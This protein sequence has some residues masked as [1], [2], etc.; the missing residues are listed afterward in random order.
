MTKSTKKSGGPKNKKVCE[1]SVRPKTDPKIN[2]AQ[3]M[4]CTLWTE[5]VEFWEVGSA[6]FTVFSPS[7]IHGLC[8]LFL[9]LIHGLCAFFRLLLTPLSTAHW[10]ASAE[11]QGEE[12]RGNSTLR[13][14]HGARVLLRDLPYRSSKWHYRQRKIIFELIM[15][16]IA[17]TD[18]DENY[19]GINFS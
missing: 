19:F 1:R 5:T 14:V 13:G 4:K 2:G 17:D 11:A 10:R 7:Q 15:H 18:T 16:I 3:T 8:A 12:N 9:P 6:E